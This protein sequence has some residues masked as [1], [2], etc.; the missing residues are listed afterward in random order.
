M[1]KEAFTPSVVNVIKSLDVEKNK[2]L[3]QFGCES[4]DYFEA[5]KW[6]NE[7]DLTLDAMKVFES[8]ANSS[9]KGP[10]FINHRYITEDVPMGLG[11][12]ISIGK[13]CGVDTTIPESIMGLASALIG[14]DL[15]KE[16][17]TIQK[18]IG[19]DNVTKKDI[20]SAI[21]I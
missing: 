2:I 15:S 7:E 13:I 1:Y 6:R 20:E 19:K 16:A 17:R 21:G 4:L 14:R 9:N 5:A 8:F 11:L 3:N 10:S 12:F 18:L